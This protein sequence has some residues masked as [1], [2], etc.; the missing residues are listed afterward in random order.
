MDR[1]VAVGDNLGS[2]QLRFRSRL[3]HLRQAA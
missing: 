1:D 2:K 3:G